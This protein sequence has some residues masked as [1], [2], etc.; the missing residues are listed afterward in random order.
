M[1][2][3]IEAKTNEAQGQAPIVPTE[4]AGALL[5]L[6][7]PTVEV[8]YVPSSLPGYDDLLHSGTS[9]SIQKRVPGQI[10]SE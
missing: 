8:G 5:L 4:A 10:D 9:F 2:Q 3:L 7:Q 1:T 6:L